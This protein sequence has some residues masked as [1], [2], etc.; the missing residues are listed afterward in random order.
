MKKLLGVQWSWPCQEIL[1]KVELFCYTALHS[2]RSTMLDGLLDFGGNNTFGH[3]TFMQLV[4]T[5]KL[6][7]LS[8]PWSKKKLYNL[9]ST[10]RKPNG[11]RS[12]W[13]TDT[14]I[15]FF[16]YFCAQE[17]KLHVL[18]NKLFCPQQEPLAISNREISV[19]PQNFWGK[20][21]PFSA[22]KLILKEKH[23]HLLLNLV[24]TEYL[25]IGIKVLCNPIA[26]F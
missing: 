6:Q 1:F 20:A 25:T 21:M 7:D 12:I 3:V 18:N 23:S 2:A 14:S 22:N 17:A 5:L 11:I 24:E 26:Q 15:H 4:I 13:Q 9:A 19:Y 16:S 10:P 8:G